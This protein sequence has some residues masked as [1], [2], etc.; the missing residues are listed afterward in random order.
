M[1]T[2]LFILLILNARCA[3]GGEGALLAEE[4]TAVHAGAV[5]AGARFEVAGA[6]DALSRVD[7]VHRAARVVKTRT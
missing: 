4:G 1:F 5:A 2:C 3:I 7:R 6:D